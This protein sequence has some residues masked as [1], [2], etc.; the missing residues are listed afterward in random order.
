MIDADTAVGHHLLQIPQAKTV[1]EI[2]PHAKQDD[3]SIEMTAFEHE[4]RSKTEAFSW[5]T[6]ITGKFATGPFRAGS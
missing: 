1:G 5:Q 6:R 2:P 3:G 4:T